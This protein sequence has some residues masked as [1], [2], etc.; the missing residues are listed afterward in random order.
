MISSSATGAEA[1]SA[2]CKKME[3]ASKALE[4]KNQELNAQLRREESRAEKVP[5]WS[6][7]MKRIENEWKRNISERLEVFDAFDVFVRFHDLRQEIASSICFDI[8]WAERPHRCA[9]LLRLLVY[10]VPSIMFCQDNLL[11]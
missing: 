11:S 1:M 2:A 5:P 3:E 10:L 9:P 7:P 8:C 6:K 4:Q